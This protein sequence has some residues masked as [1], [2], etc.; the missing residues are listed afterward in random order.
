MPH[1]TAADIVASAKFIVI[2]RE[3]GS[4]PQDPGRRRS[5]PGKEVISIDR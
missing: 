4:F 1:A 5:Q 3:I 2:G